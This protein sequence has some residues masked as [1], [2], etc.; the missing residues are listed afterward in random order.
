MSKYN[1]T[2]KEVVKKLKA[3][4]DSNRQI[5]ASKNHPTSLEIIGVRQADVKVTIKQL[6]E[7]TTD[8]PISDKIELAKQLVKNGIL[9]CQQLAYEYINKD[10][11]IRNL[12]LEKILVNT[13][14][15][16]K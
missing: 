11:N 3:V 10:K 8:W 9:E 1:A 2:I 7:E 6:R 13:L 5:F 12:L 4:A 16:V 14:S 15:S